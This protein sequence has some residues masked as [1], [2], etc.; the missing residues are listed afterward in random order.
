MSLIVDVFPARS[1]NFGYLVHD[2]ATGR[3]AAIDAPEVAAIKN[4]LLHR[5]WTLTDIFITH[6]HIDHVEAIP[7]LKAEYGAR[8]VGP[9]GEADKIEGLDELVAGGDTV[10]LGETVF[11]VYDAPGHTLGHIVFHDTVGKHLFSADAL[12]SLGVGRMFEGT[13]GPM[14]E[15][16]KALR[17]LPDD[18]LVYCGHEYTE[19]NAKFALSIDPDNA[20]LQTRAAEVK[21]LREAGRATIP[22]LLG[23]DKAAN[24]FLRADDAGLARHF[25]LEGADAAEVFAAIRRG[26][27]NF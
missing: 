20:A 10:S 4:A 2:T 9:R 5:G 15:G 14:W 7:E 25:G 23:E 22:F 26:K 12:F 18:T 11:A 21:A 16:V 3:T 24:P 6:H 8:V 19:S 1:D 17:N 13:A 27:D